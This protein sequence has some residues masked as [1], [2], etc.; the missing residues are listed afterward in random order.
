MSSSAKSEARRIRVRQDGRCVNLTPTDPTLSSA[1]SPWQGA[2]LER[3][4]HGPYASG[5]HVHPSH[6]LSL[7][8]SGPAPVL[9][10]SNGKSGSVT[11][12]PGSITVLS[13]GTE[14]AVSF[15]RPM[16]RL[17]LTLDPAVLGRALPDGGA[18]REFD[19]VERWGI[20]DP[21]IEHVMRALEADLEAGLPTGRLFGESLLGALAVHLS[22]LY[23]AS[24][25]GGAETGNGLPKSRLNRVFDFVE[26]NLHQQL[27]LAALAETVEMSPH[28]FSALFKRSTTFSPHQYVLRR[29]IERAR[30]LLHDPAISV[31]EAGIRSGFSEA[32]HFARI[33]RRIVGVTPTE[34]RS[35]L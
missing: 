2:L 30:N 26:A 32:S 31:F 16:K 33:F 25:S 10:R 13:R 11:L 23:G 8:L 24:P 15:L 1:G 35:G 19:L 17:L 29:R 4:E 5:I 28:Y 27:T 34:Y 12:E 14:D 3:H 6:F 7:H 18:A 20:R 9:W 22:N 21:Q